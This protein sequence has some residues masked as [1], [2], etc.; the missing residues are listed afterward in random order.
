MLLGLR[1]RFIDP[2]AHREFGDLD[3][4]FALLRGALAAIPRRPQG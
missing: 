3:D 2:D 4:G 1:A